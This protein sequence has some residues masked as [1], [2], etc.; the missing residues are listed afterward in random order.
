MPRDY[1]HRAQSRK[2]RQSSPWAWFFVGILVGA[3]SVGLAWLK[4][5]PTVS[6]RPAV[7]RGPAPVAVPP[8]PQPD[9]GK[10]EQRPSDLPPPRF[11]Y[12]SVLP[13]MEVVIPPEDLRPKTPP[14]PPPPKPTAMPELPGADTRPVVAT[15]K[16]TPGAKAVYQLQL[17]SFRNSGDAERLK[18]SLALIG[19]TARI[20]KVTIDDK[21]TY[22]RVRSGPFD[23][24]QAYG[25]HN[26]LK[27][28]RVDSMIVRARG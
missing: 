3:V 9:A 18:A 22:F 26:R 6:G 12:Y 25:L 27:D 15:P 24:E 14:P 23:K 16:P 17:G 5:D 8:P 1:K 28:N 19:I 21:G 7:A 20:E 13:E 11:E 4:W 10:Q 2:R